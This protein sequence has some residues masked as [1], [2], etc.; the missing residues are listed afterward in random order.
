MGRSDLPAYPSSGLTVKQ[1]ETLRP[2]PVRVMSVDRNKPAL[3]LR[4][5]ETGLVITGVTKFP[6]T[7]SSYE[8]TS[9]DLPE[10]GACGMAMYETW[11]KGYFTV[12]VI[13]WIPSDLP[14]NVDA[15]AHRASN[16][17]ANEG[18]A[19]RRRG[20]HRRPFP[21]QRSTTLS[22]GYHEFQGAGWDRMAQDLSE[23]HLDSNRRDWT[24]LTGRSL[25]YTEAGLRISGPVNRPGADTGLVPEET[26]P[27]GTTRQVVLL[28][29]GVTASSRYLTGEPDALPFVESLE[30]IQEFGLDFPVPR[31]VLETSYLDDLVG[32]AAS[33]WDRT[34]VLDQNGMEVDGQGFVL[35]LKE[36]PFD[37]P[38]DAKADAV[39][40]PGTREGATPKRRGWAIERV[41]G[42]LVGYHRPDTTTYGKVLKPVLFPLSTAGRFGTDLETGFRPVED[43]KDHVEARLAAVASLTRFP[44]DYNTTRWMVT[45]EG[46]VLFEVGATL[47]RENIGLD[48]NLYE[49]PWGAGRS[50]E[51]HVVG[52]TR[53]LLGKNRDEEDSLDLRT[54]GQV[55]LRLGADDGA[56][57][58]AGRSVAVQN[59]AHG[60]TPDARSLQYWT[61]PKLTPGDA[62][63]LDA[64][65]KTGA[66]NVS[67]RAA[68][69]GGVFL[70]LGARN[71]AAKRRHLK[72]GFSDGQGKTAYAPGKG[73]RAASKG[74]ETYGAGD[75]KY[76]FHDLAQAGVNRSGE[77]LYYPAGDCIQD[78]DA[79][80]LSADIHACQDILLRVGKNN[81][82]NYSILLDL[83]GGVIG[84]VGKDKKGRSL[85]ST[86]E[87]GVEMSIGSADN[88]M[89]MQLEVVG[90]VNWVI[91]GNWHV[92]CTGD[93]VF[94]SMSSIY[95]LAK[96]NHV[97]KGTNVYSSAL[98][99]IVQEAPDMP[100]NQ[101]WFA[102][103]S[104]SSDYRS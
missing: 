90:D 8:T 23:D 17:A 48:T 39:V 26:L 68:T 35:D 16:Y 104:L 89:A 20:V 63:S 52:S 32:A 9:M 101:G 53:L 72:N 64:G 91:R 50:I 37:H 83:D 15:V 80:G 55:V 42:T 45:K 5:A 100:K 98:A 54:L 82:S 76:R 60:D 70:R 81:L 94:D 47:P 67:L 88:G 57:P 102:S 46:Q 33:P 27:D 12:A 71:A 38:Y 24:R 18:Y 13:C 87:G 65:G 34:T 75:T 44:H 21:G 41:T 25:D 97:T 96:K 95:T 49:H 7:A 40:G 6:V 84:I 51:G 58:D 4:H 85:V 29:P 79:H 77:M 99:K 61:N 59:R 14:S 1:E 30:R 11:S 19:T 28:K 78:M 43:S 69:D 74:R 2:F 86:M 73:S 36:Q 93:M 10:V 22:S 103:P 3:T 31:E 56:L 92:H 62:G 66:E